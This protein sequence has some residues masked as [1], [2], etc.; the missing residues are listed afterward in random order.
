MDGGRGTLLNVGNLLG[1][2]LFRITSVELDV[3]GHNGHNWVDFLVL[4]TVGED[5][6]LSSSN[7]S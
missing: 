1:V 6:L 5:G 3:A 7:L 4:H 2:V